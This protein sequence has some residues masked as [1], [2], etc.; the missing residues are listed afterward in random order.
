MKKKNEK[1]YFSQ[2]E[3]KEMWLKY[4]QSPRATNLMGRR[5]SFIAKVKGSIFGENRGGKR[6]YK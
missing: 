1:K 4:K 6:K 2:A 3:I 5:Q